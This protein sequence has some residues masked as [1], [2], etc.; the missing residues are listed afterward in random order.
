VD[1]LPVIAVFVVV[2]DGYGFGRGWNILT[3]TGQ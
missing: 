2:A 3:S 1:V